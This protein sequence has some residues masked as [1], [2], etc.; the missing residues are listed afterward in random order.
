MPAIF[1]S[2]VISP[3]SARDGTLW[4]TL[5]QPNPDAEGNGSHDTFRW[6]C[7]RHG[8][9][10]KFQAYIKPKIIK[11]VDHFHSN[12]SSSYTFEGNLKILHSAFETSILK[13]IQH[14][15]YKQEFMLKAL[16][17]FIYSINHQEKLEKTFQNIVIKNAI[18]GCHNW[19]KRFYDKDA[20]IFDDP[21]L[22]SISDYLKTIII[23][24]FKTPD[25]ILKAIDI[26]IFLMKEDIYYRPRWIKILQDV[27][28][29]VQI[30]IRESDYPLI[31]ILRGVC[32]TCENMVLTP[33]EIDNVHRWH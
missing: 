12:F 3:A 33:E 25:V 5:T 30:V 27:N 31:R 10:K 22:S 4:D 1:R 17:I 23:S 2:R 13:N 20:Y 28:Q 19:I 9:G 21:R 14:E 29:T 8:T 15:Q 6:N 26:I 7:Y 18:L 16:D 32:E 11:T 24:E